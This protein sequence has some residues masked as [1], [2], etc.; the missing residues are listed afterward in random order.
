MFFFFR[1]NIADCIYVSLDMS[2]MKQYFDEHVDSIYWLFKNYKLEN[3]VENY[4]DAYR[5]H[6]KT[7]KNVDISV[8]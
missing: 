5:C 7:S 4:R 8:A 1:C 3:G 6:F 2:E